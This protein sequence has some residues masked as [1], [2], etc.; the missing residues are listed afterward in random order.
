MGTSGMRVA[1]NSYSV[2]CQG[3]RVES[4]HKRIAIMTN[5][6]LNM[7]TRIIVMLGANI[8][9]ANEN[10]DQPTTVCNQYAPHS[11]CLISL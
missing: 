7:L 5:I 2:F 10:N 9:Y 6:N 1:L 8:M 3:S 4:S 11:S